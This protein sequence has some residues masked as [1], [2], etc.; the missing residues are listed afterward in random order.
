MCLFS[1]RC[2]HEYEIVC[3]QDIY[4]ITN[5]STSNVVGDVNNTMYTNYTQSISIPESLINKLNECN[6][7]VDD[8]INALKNVDFEKDKQINALKKQLDDIKKHKNNVVGHYMCQR[9]VK[10]GDV[11]ETTKYFTPYLDQVENGR[12]S[13]F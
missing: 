4:D 9:C 10:C 2:V 1:K 12:R 11:K 6:I 7:S 3:N 8:I 5:D 13:L